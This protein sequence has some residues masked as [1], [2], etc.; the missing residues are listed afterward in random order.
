MLTY[1][2]L[3][4]KLYTLFIRI[5]GASEKNGMHWDW[6]IT[7]QPPVTLSLAVQRTLK[8][9]P[10]I[11]MYKNIDDQHFGDVNEDTRRLSK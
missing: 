5:T 6:L 11:F 7:S 4:T 3:Y 9:L 10:N 2:R 1:Y 8:I